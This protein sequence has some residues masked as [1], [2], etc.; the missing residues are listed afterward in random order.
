[1]Q[2]VTSGN[3]CHGH[4]ASCASRPI[5]TSL[6]FQPHFIYDTVPAWPLPGGPQA[7]M[8]RGFS[9]SLCCPIGIRAISHMW[10]ELG[11]K[12]MSL[13]GSSGRAFTHTHSQKGTEPLFFCDG[14]SLSPLTRVPA[15][16]ASDVTWHGETC[17]CDA[18]DARTSCTID[19]L[20]NLAASWAP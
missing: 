7:Q 12:S 16:D 5:T 3:R 1:M 13:S 15:K 10:H 8:L 6:A 19:A 2:N 11:E 17:I 4:P 20:N 9:R 14:D 18:L